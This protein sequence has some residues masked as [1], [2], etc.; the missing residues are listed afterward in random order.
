MQVMAG[1]VETERLISFTLDQMASRNEHHIF[2]EICF[3]I[4][5][6]RLSSNLLR[7]TGPVSAGGDQGRDAETYYTRLPEEV[8]GEQGFS[9]NATKEPLVVAASVQRNGLENKILKDLE[10]I[11]ERGQAVTQVAYFSSQNIAVATRHRLQ[12]KAAEHFQV[13]LEIFDRD[14]IS[15]MLC[16]D[17]LIW[18]AKTY[19][20]IAPD[21]LSNAIGVREIRLREFGVH[22]AIDIAEASDTMPTYVRRDVDDTADGIRAHLERV[23]N[24]G[25][26]LLIGHSSVGKTRTLVEAVQ[27]VLPDWRVI[28]PRDAAHLSEIAGK[29][30][31]KVVVWLDD[32][33]RHLQVFDAATARVLIDGGAVLAGTI[34]PAHYDRYMYSEKLHKDLA[35]HYRARELLKLADPAYLPSDFSADELAR[36]RAAADAGDRQLA[37]ALESDDFGVPQTLAGAPHLVVRWNHADSYAKA[38][39]SAAVDYTRLGVESGLPPEVLRA[40]APGYCTASQRAAA[41]AD[42]FEKAVSYATQ[43]LHG[44]TSALIPVSHGTKMGVVDSYR[45]ADY[46]LHH[47]ASERQ[48]ACLPLTFW[49]AAYEYL[50]VRADLETLGMQAR[51]RML[52]QNALRLFQRA[53]EDRDLIVANLQ[54]GRLLLDQQ[55]HREAVDLLRSFVDNQPGMYGTVFNLLVLH[56]DKAECERF[57]R[58]T[59]DKSSF[60]ALAD[61]AKHV[62]TADRRDVLIAINLARMVTAFGVMQQVAK[63]DESYGSP[64]DELLVHRLLIE[65]TIKAA[66]FEMTIDQWEALVRKAG[67]LALAGHMTS[68]LDTLYPHI[69]VGVPYLADWLNSLLANYDNPD[70][71]R[72]L[73]GYGLLESGEIDRH[74]PPRQPPAKAA[75]RHPRS[76]APPA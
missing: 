13:R 61:I 23:R 41:P 24:G 7:A 45:V 60:E 64:I 8:P 27:A 25:F 56:V 38:V 57:D 20:H 33:Q 50:P 15:C 36:A 44:S 1:P 34:W 9:G 40:A 28:Q 5:A 18:I 21:P 55:R 59:I 74:R 62:V 22:R 35:P 58:K 52:Y 42:W 47:A 32:L 17:D 12:D 48:L 11:C 39:L 51:N 71:A 46:L 68:A 67:L 69:A 53:A 31:T 30:V 14:N 3:R 26:V 54:A 63:D 75:P 6:Q 70:D 49:D 2:E 4:A 16:A 73:K 65:Q 76:A 10:S 43:L 29:A 66:G 72:V 37:A 19:L